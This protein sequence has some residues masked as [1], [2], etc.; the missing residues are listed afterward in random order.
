MSRDYTKL[1]RKLYTYTVETRTSKDV[2]WIHLC[3]GITSEYDSIRT[4]K[5]CSKSEMYARVLWCGMSS[6]R[7]VA[8]YHVGVYVESSPMWVND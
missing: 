6:T 2:P 1:N 8:V 5:V 4:A 7:Q 3:S